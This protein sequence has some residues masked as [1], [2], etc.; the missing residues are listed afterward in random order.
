MGQVRSA[1]ACDGLLAGARTSVDHGRQD[2]QRARGQSVPDQLS[3]DADEQR[4]RDRLRSR[5]VGRAAQSVRG[6]RSVARGRRPRLLPAATAAG[7][8]KGGSL[9]FI[10]VVCFGLGLMAMGKTKPKTQVRKIVCLGPRTGIVY[11]VED[12]PEIGT[13]VVRTPDGK[14]V[15]Q[16]VRAAMRSPGAP[17]LIYQTGQGDPRLLEA[18]RKDFGIEP[19]PLTAV[20]PAAASTA[21][22]GG[23]QERPK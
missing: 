13:L 16:F 15:A 12:F 5:R 18:M 19:K 4:H 14:A 23:A 6:P 9:M 11:P 1:L 10:P 17:G 22:A 8:Q 3:L 2:R 20:A 7:S 21:A